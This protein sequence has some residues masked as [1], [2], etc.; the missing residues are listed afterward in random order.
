M[1]DSSKNGWL[2]RKAASHP[3]KVKDS[4]LK[5]WIDNALLSRIQKLKSVQYFN[6]Q[7]I[8][9]FCDVYTFCAE[10]A[11]IV[12]AGELVIQKWAR[13][14]SLHPVSGPRID[15]CH[16]YVFLRADV[17]K[18]ISRKRKTAPQMARE[19]GIGRSQIVQWI[20]DGK[21]MPARGTGIDK[22]KHYL[23]VT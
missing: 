10:A 6:K 4:V 11:K 15:N 9:L 17:E 2:S 1:Y 5:K 23:F 21:T 14:G 13:N 3:L 18:L 12:S 7:D 22:S 19:L 16:R 20:Q 8:D